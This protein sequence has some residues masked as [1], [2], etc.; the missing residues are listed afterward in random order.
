MKIKLSRFEKAKILWSIKIKKRLFQYQKEFSQSVLGY[1]VSTYGYQAFR[2]LFNE[3]FIKQDY[4]FDAKTDSPLIIDCGANI[5]MS[6]LYFKILYPKSKIIAF[7][8]SPLA[9]KLL[10][11]NVKQNKLQNVTLVN[12]ALSDSDG[13][14]TFYVHNYKGSLT[15]SLDPIRGGKN[16][17]T[18]KVERLSTYLKD[19]N[20]DL[21]KMDVEG[22]EWGILRD[23]VQSKTLGK[24]QN[25]LIEY[26]H[27]INE[28]SKKFGEFLQ[29]FEKVDFGYN[30]I[31]TSNNMGEL[32]DIFLKIYKECNVV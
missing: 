27:R 25:Y 1:K 14:M 13:D 26:H 12:S 20:C 8:P 16:E 6:V 19:R 24:T 5:G 28:E 23:L 29:F 4:Y 32:Q 9:F 15:S 18:V 22:G 17:L 21:V 7:E 30:L 3:V 31:T 2:I 10:E 11:K